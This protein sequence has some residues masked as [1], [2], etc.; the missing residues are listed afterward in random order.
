MIAEANESGV[1]AK[2][3]ASARRRLR[4]LEAAVAEAAT[5]EAQAA[6]AKARVEEEAVAKVVAE[7]EAEAAARAVAEAKAEAEAEAE[8][9]VEA[10]AEAEVEAERTSVLALDELALVG[11]KLSD[12]G[13]TD[14]QALLGNL[15]TA[16]PP[17]APHAHRV[18]NTGPPQAHRRPT[19][20]AQ[21]FEELERTLTVWQSQRCERAV[22]RESTEARVFVIA[23][24][25][26]VDVL[27]HV[28]MAETLQATRRGK[29]RKLCATPLCRS[30]FPLP[31]LP[32]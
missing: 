11:S 26:P 12:V 1:P 6:R 22:L 4:Q 31:S 8:V 25:P 27:A 9:E 20:S 7:A 30:Y 2:P 24:R 19:A 32:L 10:E 3:L 21:A 15:S 13:D 16:C 18:P 5:E 17:H 28:S 14:T 23:G 29:R